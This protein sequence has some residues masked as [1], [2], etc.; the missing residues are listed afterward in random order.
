MNRFFLCLCAIGLLVSCVTDDDI[1]EGNDGNVTS[2]TS[3][4]FP[5]FSLVELGAGPIFFNSREVLFN[6]NTQN[7]NFINL[8]EN[9]G[10]FTD[11][12]FIFDKYYLTFD[13]VGIGEELP[14]F[15]RKQYGDAGG[16][17]TLPAI[18]NEASGFV[19][20]NNR[21][22][23]RSFLLDDNF[24][25]DF[26]VFNYLTGETSI[27]ESTLDF[28]TSGGT[29]FRVFNN[30]YLVV[31]NET[32][33]LKTIVRFYDLNSLTETGNIIIDEIISTSSTNPF[34]SEFIGDKLFLTGAGTT[35]TLYE[36][37]LSNATYIGK[38]I[39]NIF[40]NQRSVQA[41]GQIYLGTKN[42]NN[43]L[44]YDLTTIDI[45]NGNSVSLDI[46]DLILERATNNGYFTSRPYKFTY[47]DDQNVWILS[48]LNFT[49]DNFDEADIE[50]LKITNEGEIVGVIELPEDGETRPISN[51]IAN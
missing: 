27:I 21:Q 2:D 49:N 19:L 44:F 43:E 10:G 31:F 1:T 8:S 51:L 7:F 23:V 42:S 13:F 48:V 18:E 24:S 6:E 47:S 37:D 39:Y 32:N 11:R 46:R 3:T 28:S 38:R 30:D 17:Y 35:N 45:T 34:V 5:D 9:S 22:V 16:M 15:I 25:I 12:V 41:N 36:F 20:V 40:E 26:N 4:D 29:Q 14:V 50:F 33:D